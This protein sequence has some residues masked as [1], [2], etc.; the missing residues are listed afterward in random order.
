MPPLG[1]P[2]GMTPRAARAGLVLAAAVGWAAGPLAAAGGPVLVGE[3]DQA[4]EQEDECSSAATSAAGGER[5]ALNALQLQRQRRTARSEAGASAALAGRAGGRAATLC[6][7]TAFDISEEGCCGGEVFKLTSQSCCGDTAVYSF[8][9]QGCCNKKTVFSLSDSA[10]CVDATPSTGKRPAK[11]SP[12]KC[13]AKWPIPAAMYGW[14][15]YCHAGQPKVWAMNYDCTQAYYDNKS[16]SIAGANATAVEKCNQQGDKPCYLFDKNGWAC[17][18]YSKVKFCGSQSYDG[19]TQGCCGGKVF[20][21]GTQDCCGMRV[22]NKRGQDCCAGKVF[23]TSKY[24]CCAHR[25]RKL[26]KGVLYRTGSQGCC[27]DKGIQLYRMGTQQ[28][29]HRTG[30]CNIQQGKWSCCG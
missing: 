1:P 7:G 12:F 6:N 4:W 30:V 9:T 26:S 5:C 21:T 16:A 24:A 23:P 20:N 27:L 22:F 8:S 17:G 25:G 19:S 28:C 13:Q 14:T 29:C 10:G 3:V 18:E 15:A 2:S 11:A